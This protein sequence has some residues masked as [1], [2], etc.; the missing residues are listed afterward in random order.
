M[1]LNIIR[2]NND[3]IVTIIKLSF[4]YGM[5]MDGWQFNYIDNHTM[6]FKKKRNGIENINLTK[7]LKKHL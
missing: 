2:M 6:E 3:L 1:Q 4:I 7:L 5:I